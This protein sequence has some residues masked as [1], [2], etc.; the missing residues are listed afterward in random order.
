MHRSPLA[1][2]FILALRS[3]RCRFSE[4]VLGVISLV[5]LLQGASSFVESEPR[6]AT[7]SSR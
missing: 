6:F 3:P 7:A 2:S 1:I 4:L 5:V